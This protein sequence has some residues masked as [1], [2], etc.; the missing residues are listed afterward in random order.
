MNAK[1]ILAT[2]AAALL[3]SALLLYSCATPQEQE[4]Q[5]DT[6]HAKIPEVAPG[7]RL[8]AENCVRCHNLR[9]LDSYTDSEWEVAV[10]HMRV[11]ANLT[12]EEHRAILSFLKHG[13]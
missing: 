6:A 13:F 3:G 9:P 10:H 7:A 8:W 1:L 11:R 4:T 5:P 12:A 2:M